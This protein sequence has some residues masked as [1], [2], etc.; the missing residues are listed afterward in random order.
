[1]NIPTPPNERRRL[2]VLWQYDLLDSP[3]EQPLEDLTEL[4]RCICET[5]IALIS[6]VDEHR[7]WFKARLGVTEKETARDISFCTHAILQN[8]VMIVPDAHQDPR[9]ANSPL[10]TSSPYIRFYAGAPL[11]TP[12]GH[13]LGTLCVVDHVPRQ[14][15]ERQIRALETLA[16]VV[17]SYL[18][19]RRQARELSR[20][21]IRRPA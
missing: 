19:L 21:P 7:Q 20:V 14:L 18:D 12:D 6:L 10:V 15:T 2:E 13:A 11:I 5:P 1:M 16:R 17:M 8:A 3:P 4:A 9:F